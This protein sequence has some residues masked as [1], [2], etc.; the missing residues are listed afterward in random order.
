MSVC[1]DAH[2]IPLNRCLSRKKY[3]VPVYYMQCESKMTPFRH[4]EILSQRLRILSKVLH[5]YI[6]LLHVASLGK[7]YR[8]HTKL[9]HITCDH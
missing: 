6:R 5:A 2:E 1:F 7:L 8:N 3:C 9:C 4:S